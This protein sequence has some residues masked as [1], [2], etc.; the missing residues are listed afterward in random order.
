V[1]P[2]RQLFETSQGG[3]DSGN[4][5]ATLRPGDTLIV[6]WSGGNPQDAATFNVTG[7]LH[8]LTVT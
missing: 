1:F 4:F 8:A 2:H 3:G 6:V 5:E 7:E